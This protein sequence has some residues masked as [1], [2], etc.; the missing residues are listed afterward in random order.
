MK[1]WQGRLSGDV[2]QLAAQLN[3]SLAFDSRLAQVDI[4]GSIAWTS[5]LQAAGIL[6]AEEAKTIQD[7]LQAVLTE[8]QQEGFVFSD[9]DEDIHTAVER[10]LTEL[11]GPLG[12]KLH[13]GRSRNDQVV[14]DFRLWVKDAVLRVDELIKQLQ[15]TLCDQAQSH[16]EIIMPGYTHLQQA[17]PVLLSHWWLSHFWPLQRDR[18][19]LADLLEETDVL[20]LGC[21]ALAGSA[22]PIDRHKLSEAL[23]FSRPAANSMDAVSDRDFA[24]DFVYI[25]AMIGTHLSR[26]SEQLI[27]FSSREFGFFTLSD[28]YATGSSIM[29]QKKNPD[30]L[31]IIRSKTATFNGQLMGMLTLLKALPSVYDKDMQDD[32]PAVFACFDTLELILPVISGVVLTLAVNQQAIESAL[33]PALMATDL[34]DH[35]VKNG[36]PFREA[37]AAVGQAVRKAVDSGVPLDE[38]PLESWQKIHSAFDQELFKVI[39]PRSS[40]TKRAVF[41]GTAPDAVRD[42][43]ELAQNELGEK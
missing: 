1:L 6:T 38:L 11:I 31:E 19:K 29:P 28:A 36:I 21:G 41:G 39:D 40:V 16:L 8:F 24:V 25:S 17:Q 43:L 14:T 22:Y 2:D 10:R 30:M 33:D 20:P 13:T 18:K 34:A 12:G 5:A 37:Y 35:L 27:L 4:R 42:Q 9:A 32:K 3:S 7:G 15:Q 23:G 26:L